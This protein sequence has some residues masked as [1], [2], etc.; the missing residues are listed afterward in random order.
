MNKV[1]SM[2]PRLSSWKARNDI[3][4]AQEVINKYQGIK[5]SRNTLDFVLCDIAE[6]EHLNQLEGRQT[7]ARFQALLSL[8]AI[9]AAHHQEGILK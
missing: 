9:K 6:L 4:T 2:P 7:P 5:F 8:Q 1:H 3:H